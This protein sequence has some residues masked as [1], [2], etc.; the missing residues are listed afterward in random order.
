MPYFRV[1]I[2]ASGL[3]ILPSE[4]MGPIAGFYTTRIVRAVQASEAAPKAME[5]LTREWQSTSLATK[6][7]SPHLHLSLDEVS[8]V[9][10]LVG[11]FRRM[12]GY[13]FYSEE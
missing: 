11:L 5:L 8:Q 6:S 9:S 3:N 4:G 13:T 10:T 12:R 1:R 7:A 2:H